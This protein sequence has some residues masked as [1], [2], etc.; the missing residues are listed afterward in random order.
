MNGQGLRIYDDSM[1]EVA[2]PIRAATVYFH[3]RPELT[4]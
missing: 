2:T 4:A 3:Y 1:V